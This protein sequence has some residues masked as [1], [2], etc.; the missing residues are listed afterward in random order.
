MLADLK[1]LQKE[2]QNEIKF[3]CVLISV[4]LTV[5]ILNY[6]WGLLA[7]NVF[8]TTLE[9]FSANMPSQNGQV[10]PYLSIISKLV[11]IVHLFA[12]TVY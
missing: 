2:C 11:E 1:T 3:S 5:A 9:A 8:G 4:T 12:C 6:W 7:F 10:C